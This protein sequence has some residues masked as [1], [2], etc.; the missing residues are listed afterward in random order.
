MSFERVGFVSNDKKDV[1]MRDEIFKMW[2]DSKL[3]C[4][5]WV[6]LVLVNPDVKCCNKTMQ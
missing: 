2:L 1:I 4:Y 5:F 3:R 6:G